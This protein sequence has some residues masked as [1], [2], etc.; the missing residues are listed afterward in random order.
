[1][2]LVLLVVLA[3][4]GVSVLV[5]ALILWRD[6]PTNQESEGTIR[7]GKDTLVDVSPGGGYG[8]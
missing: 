7:E 6:T 2:S 4:A 3:V 5:G 1:M 8:G